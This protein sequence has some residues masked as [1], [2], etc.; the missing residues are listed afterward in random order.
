MKTKRARV[1]ATQPAPAFNPTIQL[2]D[3]QRQIVVQQP[4]QEEVKRFAPALQG[5]E[6]RY[7]TALVGK[8]QQPAQTAAATAGAP[9]FHFAGS[10][11]EKVEIHAAPG[12]DGEEIYKKFMP[13]FYREVKH[14]AMILSSADRGVLL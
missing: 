3:H 10:M 8:K 4:A 7:D 13:V 11:V 1:S 9:Q 6:S 12:D 5:Q 2:Q 14:A